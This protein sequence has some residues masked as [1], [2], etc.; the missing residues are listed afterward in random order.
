MGTAD[1]GKSPGRKGDVTH[2]S[3]ALGPSAMGHLQRDSRPGTGSTAPGTPGR[4]PRTPPT[5]P[6]P[7]TPQNGAQQAA[8]STPDGSPQ[9]ASTLPADDRPRTPRTP[10][11]VEAPNVQASADE[12]AQTP[13]EKKEASCDV[14]ANRD[15]SPEGVPALQ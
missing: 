2:I 12:L 6:K 11:D 13:A 5:P 3:P 10:V 4:P 15:D 8:A 14:E 1:C 9:P 7:S